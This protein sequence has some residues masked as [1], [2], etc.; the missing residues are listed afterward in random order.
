M[1]NM[2]NALPGIACDVKSCAYHAM[3]DKCTAPSIK[4]GGAC[5][6]TNSSNTE[7]VTFKPCK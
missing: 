2:K 6:C 7:C 1:E 3:E 5:D 4:V